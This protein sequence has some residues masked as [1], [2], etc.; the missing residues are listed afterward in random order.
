MR[1]ISLITLLTISTTCLALPASAQ[2]ATL[3][4]SNSLLKE[5]KLTPSAMHSCQPQ[6]GEKVIVLEVNENYEGLQM[7]VAKVQVAQGKCQG[8]IGWVGLSRLKLE[9]NK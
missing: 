6:R 9:E 5:L 3:T 1:L 4:A 8:Q 2:H 7:N